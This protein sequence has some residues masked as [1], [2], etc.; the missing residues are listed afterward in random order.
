MFGERLR[1][2][3]IKKE[4]TQSELA[5][6][7]KVAPSTISMYEQGKRDPDTQALSFLADFFD[8]SVDYLLGRTDDP[9]TARV[10]GKDLPIELQEL[11]VD[12]IEVIKEMKDKGLSPEYIKRIVD[13]IQ[14]DKK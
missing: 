1:S 10:D 13:A 8:V 5:K 11:G 9:N 14:S 4:I 6:T 3:R 12:Y 7:L 2:L